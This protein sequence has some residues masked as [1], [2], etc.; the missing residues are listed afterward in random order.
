MLIKKK[1]QSCLKE[2]SSNMDHARTMGLKALS[3]IE[4]IF[5]IDISELIFSTHQTHEELDNLETVL[6]AKSHTASMYRYSVHVQNQPENNTQPLKQRLWDFFTKVFEQKRTLS[7]QLLLIQVRIPLS[8]KPILY[9]SVL[10][11][12]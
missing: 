1:T 3:E 8:W 5:S 10:W 6:D 4:L 2:L 11:S 7:N 12:C 9:Q